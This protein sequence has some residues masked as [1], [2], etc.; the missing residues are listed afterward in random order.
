MAGTC[1]HCG[2]YLGASTTCTECGSEEVSTT[3]SEWAETGGFP[4]PE[5]DFFPAPVDGSVGAFAVRGVVIAGEQVNLRYVPGTI[6]V[7]VGLVALWG[8]LVY[9]KALD[10]VTQMFWNLFWTAFPVLI[11]VVVVA[12]LASRVGMGG[13]LTAAFQ[14]SLFS[15]N[16]D[17]FHTG[18]RL[19]VDAGQS[20][21]HVV[22]VAGDLPF[23]A[24]HELVVHGP[25]VGGARHAWL[26]QGIAPV[27]YT[28]LGRGLVGTLVVAIILVPQMVWLL[29]R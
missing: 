16:R 29:A 6:A 3:P 1:E 11:V 20:G 4:P 27:T 14:V 28:R 10:L 23:A 24:G 19:V 2:R 18:W 26:V 7:R 13:C 9:T 15:R 22:T 21:S 25:R 12:W 8:F 17:P 5:G